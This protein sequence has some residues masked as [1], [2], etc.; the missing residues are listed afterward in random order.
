MLITEFASLRSAGGVKS[1]ISDMT[2]DR[3]SDIKNT[4]TMMHTISAG[5]V[6]ILGIST[7]II[8]DKG[9]KIKT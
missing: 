5:T 2:G 3:H 4:K 1:G 9:A 8:A 6:C 7:N